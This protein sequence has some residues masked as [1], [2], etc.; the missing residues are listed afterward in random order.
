MNKIDQFVE[1]QL[2]ECERKA[3]IADY[4]EWVETGS[5]ED[6]VLHS[7]A[8][9]LSVFLFGGNAKYCSHVGMMMKDLYAGVCRHYTDK[10]FLQGY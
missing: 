1:T 4:D 3:I 6:S 7:Q 5:I 2:I 9:A 10:F 8:Q